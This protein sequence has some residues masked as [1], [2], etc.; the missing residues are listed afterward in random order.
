MSTMLA[1]WATLITGVIALLIAISSSKQF[2]TTEKMRG[3]I[4]ARAIH[5]SVW[6]VGNALRQAIVWIEKM[7][8][9]RPA[10]DVDAMNQAIEYLK[11]LRVIKID[12]TQ[13][14]LLLLAPFHNDA[15]MAL[16]D[17]VPILEE[18][19]RQSKAVLSMLGAKTINE[20]Q[21]LR[22]GVWI[23][24]MRLTKTDALLET[25][26]DGIFNEIPH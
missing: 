11:V 22:H 20:K 18:I 14:Q 26:L 7:N 23:L 2:R 17:A 6:E 12:V 15:T 5:G 1:P 8:D 3:E 16:A 21:H 10:Q 19:N 25:A 4:V 13:D 9:F 24:H